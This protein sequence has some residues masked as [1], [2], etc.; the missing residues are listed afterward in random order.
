[1]NNFIEIMR[2]YK[3][4]KDFGYHLWYSKIGGYSLFDES[5]QAEFVNNACKPENKYQLL[6]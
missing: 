1:M 5:G 6:K 3:L 4:L 2:L